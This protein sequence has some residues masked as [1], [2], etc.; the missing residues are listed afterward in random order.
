MILKK[1]DIICRPLPTQGLLLCCLSPSVA[2]SAGHFWNTG[3]TGTG[4]PMIELNCFTD[5]VQLRGYDRPDPF[6]RNRAVT[7]PNFL[8]YFLVFAI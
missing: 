8:F 6:V 2:L 7:D 4:S 3:S 1:I 5:I